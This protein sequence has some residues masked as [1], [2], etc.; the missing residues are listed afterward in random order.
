MESAKIIVPRNEEMVRN[1]ISQL[2]K[3]HVKADFFSLAIDESRDVSDTSKPLLY[4]RGM[5]SDCE[6][7]DE[8]AG[9]KTCRHY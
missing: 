9:D 6:I 5:K 8:S 3:R 1:I 2:R 7:T 4:I